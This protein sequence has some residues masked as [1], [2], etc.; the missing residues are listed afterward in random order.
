MVGACRAVN[1]MGLEGKL[2][3]VSYDTT[4]AS[5]ELIKSGAIAVAITQDPFEQGAKPLD[6][7]LNHVVM[8]QKPKQEYYYTALSIVIKENL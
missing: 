7:L 4:I 2:K 8:G 5:R 6:L 3:V 1:E